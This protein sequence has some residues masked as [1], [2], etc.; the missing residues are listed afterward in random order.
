MGDAGEAKVADLD[1]VMGDEGEIHTL[2]PETSPSMSIMS[3]KWGAGASKVG[4][5]VIKWG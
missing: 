2:S 4:E 5:W 1:E 3:T